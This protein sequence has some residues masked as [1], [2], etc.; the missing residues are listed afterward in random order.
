MCKILKKEEKC[1]PDIDLYV[2]MLLL[3]SININIADFKAVIRKVI[4]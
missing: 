1:F 2:K 3:S 4:H